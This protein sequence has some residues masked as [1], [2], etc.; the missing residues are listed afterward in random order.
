M[1]LLGRKLQCPKSPLTTTHNSQKIIYIT[2]S[3][4]NV[5]E[6]DSVHTLFYGYKSIGVAFFVVKE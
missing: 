5:L 4:H 3:G 1:E 2:S 6:M